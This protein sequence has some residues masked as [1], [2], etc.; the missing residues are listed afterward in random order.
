MAK[1]ITMQD[2]FGS[3]ETSTKSSSVGLK[4]IVKQGTLKSSGKASYSDV[5]YKSF[6]SSNKTKQQ[7]DEQ[8]AEIQALKSEVEALK[9]QIVTQNQELKSEIVS[10]ET[11]ARSKALSEGEAQGEARA[12]AVFQGQL[13]EIKSQI[14]QLLQSLSAEKEAFFKQV[15]LG[16]QE[17]LTAG[18]I[19]L[20]HELDQRDHAVIEKV[21]KNVFAILGNES[22]LVLR[23]SPSDYQLAK[24]K[25]ELWL[26]LDS[27]QVS[28]EVVEDPRLDA[29]GCRL[30]TEAGAIDARRS[31]MTS[32]LA[33]IIGQAFEQMFNGEEPEA[34]LDSPEPDLPSE[35]V[36]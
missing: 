21:V 26:P 13:D 6:D 1:K 15:E 25:V 16:T 34:P 9:R 31:H 17:L 30:E 28:V 22:Q 20:N 11:A 24:D 33:E 2:L 35:G 29:G 19:K 27:N 23:L 7:A 32:H 18:L 12:T 5:Q 4:G 8:A 14:G 10:K 36:E 3:T